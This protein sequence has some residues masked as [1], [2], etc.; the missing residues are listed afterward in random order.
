M[1]ESLPAFLVNPVLLFYAFYRLGRKVR[2]KERYMSVGAGVFV[3]GMF[4]GLAYY[5]LLF[6]VRGSSLGGVFPDLLSVVGSTIAFLLML[7]G[8]GLGTLFPGFVAI[9]IAN[10]R[11]EKQLGSKELMAQSKADA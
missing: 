7:V 9:T 2:L 10:F 3:G 6:L 1:T 8:F 4:G 11:R 5:P